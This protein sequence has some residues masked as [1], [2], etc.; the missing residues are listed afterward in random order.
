MERIHSLPLVLS[1]KTH[2][3]GNHSQADPGME[4]DGKQAG[5]AKTGN[6][7]RKSAVPARRSMPTSTHG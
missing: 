3:R 1:Y 5:R 4:E 2:T 6:S 7:I